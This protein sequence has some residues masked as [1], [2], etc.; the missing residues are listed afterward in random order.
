VALLRASE[1]KDLEFGHNQ[2]SIL[3]R[4]ALSSATMGELADYS[5]SDK[6]SVSRTVASLEK[7]GYVNRVVDTGDRRIVNIELT[8]K[9]RTL[10][11]K[12]QEIR[13]SIGERLNSALSPTDREQLV[14][15]MQKLIENLKTQKS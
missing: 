14:T 7:A 15:L 4:L 2:I 12:A 6:A 9:G 10:A 8:P 1:T 3:H 13:A 11:K 5:F